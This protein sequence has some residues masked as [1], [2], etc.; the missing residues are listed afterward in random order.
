MDNNKIAL[1]IKNDLQ[2]WQKLNVAAFLA[3]AVAI[4]FPDT[5]GKSFINASGSVYLPFI[6]QPILIYGAET[7]AEI[8]RAFHR[9]KERGL[10]V[11]IY[12]EPL[13]ATKNEEQNHVEIAKKTDET[14][15][16]VGLALYGD[17]K[18]LSKAIDG[19]KF[20]P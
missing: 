4:Q 3:S 8:K 10:Q 17:G 20:H 5:H 13:F 15:V 6:K 18:K 19:L 1:V 7:E 11:G 2:P 9:A 12:T 16:L 14:Q